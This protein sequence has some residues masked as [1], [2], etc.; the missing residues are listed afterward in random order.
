[1]RNALPTFQFASRHPAPHRG[2][3]EWDELPWDEM[4]FP[5]VRWA[6]N[7]AGEI[8]EAAQFAARSNP[9]GEVGDY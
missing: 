2:A 9:A 7:H 5:S 4:A 6:L 1:M 8:G 3:I